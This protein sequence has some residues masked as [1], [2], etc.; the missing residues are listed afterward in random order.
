MTRLLARSRRRHLLRHAVQTLL[1]VVGIMLGVAVVLAVDTAIASADRAFGLSLD[2]LTGQATHQLLGGPG[3][4]D[5]ELYR[6]LRV[7]LDFRDAAPVIEADIALV[8]TEERL[9]LFGIDPYA[10]AAFRAWSSPG[11]TL[12]VGGFLVRTGV[13]ASAA[14]LSRLGLRPG[15]RLAL[16][17][18]GR[19]REVE[20]LGTFDAGAKDR[21]ATE[22]VVLADLATAEELLGTRGRL[23]RVDLRF[24]EGTA[25]RRIAE[26]EAALGN[27]V[28]IVPATAR[29]AERSGLLLAFRQNLRFLSLLA[30]VVGALLIHQTMTFSVVR[31]REEIG[32]LRA[33]GV[34]KGEILRGVLGEAL[35]LLLVGAGLGLPLGLLLGRSLVHGVASTIGDLYF[36]ITVESVAIDP[37]SIAKAALLGALATFVGAFYPARE[38][39]RRHPR[40]VWTRSNYEEGVGRRATRLSY[41]GG[42]AF[43][44]GAALL[45]LPLEGLASCYVALFLMVAGFAF[46]APAAAAALVGLARRLGGR[47][48]GVHGRLAAGALV[49]GLSRTGLA[50]GALAVALAMSLGVALMIA[51][52][53]TTVVQWID[54]VLR[55]DLYVSPRP[56]APRLGDFDRL[57]PEVAELVRGTP[58]VRSI[59][60]N[61][62]VSVPSERGTIQLVVLALAEADRGGHLYV[63][64]DPEEADREFRAGRAVIVSEPF[65]ARHR[66]SVGDRLRLRTKSG[67]VDFGIAG[68]FRDFTTT[69]GY[70]GMARRLFDRHF[71]DR[72]LTAVA[73]FVEPGEDRAVVAARVRE[74]LGGGQE[75]LVRDELGI[76]E[77]SLEVF[78][79]TFRI[80]EVLRV[81]A[82]LVAFVGIF[83]A[84]LALEIERARERAVLRAQG[85]SRSGLFAVSTLHCGFLGLAAGLF[86]APLGIAFAAVLTG[87]INRRSFGWTLPLDVEARLVLETVLVGVVAALL[88]GVFPAWRMASVAP[89]RALRS[90]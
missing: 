38:A 10:E 74:R 77:M 59:T 64:G 15:D 37:F 26:L 80:T 67:E 75:L 39:A 78:D 84:L 48:F 56:S 12:E 40:E 30:L 65:S 70:V 86:S 51:S 21:E 72:E 79:R 81:L 85:L 54:G 49:S 32:R 16:R 69:A 73:A 90:E 5:A 23:T 42:A 66:L 83:A 14:L 36:S 9:T 27:G 8:A 46:V 1:C 45:F 18:S 52:F 29:G 47:R 62:T 6:R 31:R 58:G 24:D 41:V 28:R 13:H 61:R 25:E 71:D 43:L 57:A 55:A 63:A 68:V 35:L 87:E 19:T 44:L 50:V 20:I 76:R 7:E 33:L 4:I 82:T 53:R 34:T 22:R 2:A 3:G 60:T 88:A 11:Q 17:A 89:G